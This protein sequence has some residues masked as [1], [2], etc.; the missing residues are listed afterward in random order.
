MRPDYSL[1]IAPAEG[2]PAGFEPL[3]LHFDAKYRVNVIEELF[4]RSDRS[5]D[6]NAE[7]AENDSR[8]MARR[9]DLLKM[10]AYR[11]AIRRS[12]GAY[13]LYPG[14]D[15][16]RNTQEY[17]EYRELLPGLGA[18][19]FR[20]SLDGEAVGSAALQQFLES[21][22]DH[23]AM[24]FSA[25]E[26]GRFWIEETFG[27]QPTH[28]ED[29]SLFPFG[30]PEKNT[31]VLLGYVKNAEHWEWI[32]QRRMYNVRTE[33]RPGGVAANAEV[34]YSQLLL[35]YG[36]STNV[37]AIARIVAGPERISREAIRA[38]GYPDPRSD[39]LCVQL[40]R[41]YEN[42]LFPQ[43]SALDVERLAFQLSGMRGQP[44]MVTWGQLRAELGM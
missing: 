44:V 35:L 9:D 41:L 10:H 30:M 39:Y 12:A 33:G 16:P 7:A 21:V 8:R 27:V 25:H 17:R 5:E 37:V 31:P 29:V 28:R 13:V 3:I 1:I 20:P 32:R 23:V 38:T 26:R 36:P 19:V 43:A 18:F 40:S 34:L 2:E 11:D 42:T 6:A 4:G 22:L 15:S 24:R 14:D